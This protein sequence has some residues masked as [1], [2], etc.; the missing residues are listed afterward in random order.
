MFLITNWMCWVKDHINWVTLHFF[1][2]R[3]NC[4]LLSRLSQGHEDQ[5]LHSSFASQHNWGH[6]GCPIPDLHWTVPG[7]AFPRASA[8]GNWLNN[9]RQYKVQPGCLHPAFIYLL[10][11][12]LPSVPK[13]TTF[14]SAA[15]GPCSSFHGE[16]RG[17]WVGVSYI[18]PAQLWHSMTER[19]CPFGRADTWHSS[20]Q[21]SFTRTRSGSFSEVILCLVGARSVPSVKR[22]I[23][24]IKEPPPGK[25]IVLPESL[26]LFFPPV[27]VHSCCWAPGLTP[28][29]F[30]VIILMTCGLI[31]IRMCF[32]SC[33][34]CFH[35][36][37][38]FLLCC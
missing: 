8:R 28:R 5:V 37:L 18:W 7:F 2:F 19:T 14:L 34:W 13:E 4:S 23:L 30:V 36:P 29:Q 25:G 9:L 33:R 17:G 1:W 35:A 10:H 16:N 6:R 27:Q 3:I 21:K 38:L 15:Q 32:N 26:N 20:P 12:C 24:K 11:S 31:D 22:E